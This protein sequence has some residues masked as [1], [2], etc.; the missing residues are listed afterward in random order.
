LTT[1]GVDALERLAADLEIL[2][3]GWSRLEEACAGVPATVTHGDYRLRHAYVRHRAT[4]LDLLLLNWEMAGWGVPTVDLTHIDL[5][6]YL[7]VIQPTSPV[8]ELEDL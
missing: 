6:A 3:D 8:L 7:A 5:D 1:P 2:D 4:G